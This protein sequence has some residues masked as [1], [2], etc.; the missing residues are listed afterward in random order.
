MSPRIRSRLTCMESALIISPWNRFPISMASLDLPVPVAP[1]ITTNDGP[2]AVRKTR[3]TLP[4]DAAMMTL[5]QRSAD[6]DAHAQWALTSMGGVCYR[7]PGNRYLGDVMEG[8]VEGSSSFD[9]NSNIFVACF[10]S[11]RLE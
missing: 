9:R 5:S 2:I 8:H 7:A 1:R 3:F 11:N 10:H 4:A 6:G